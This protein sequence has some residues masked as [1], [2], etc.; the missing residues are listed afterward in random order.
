MNR[1]VVILATLGCLGLIGLVG[2]EQARG[3]FVRIRN[4]EQIGGSATRESLAL[5]DSLDRVGQ[6]LE[7]LRGELQSHPTQEVDQRVEAMREE[8]RQSDARLTQLLEQLET[9]SIELE[10]LRSAQ[11][12]F[13]P[14]TLNASLQVFDEEISARWNSVYHIASSAAEL[15]GRSQ[16]EVDKLNQ[17]LSDAP[18]NETLWR[19]LLGPV[20]QLSGDDSI[21][22]GVLFLSPDSA[23]A[24]TYVLTAWHVVRDIQ[25]SLDQRDMPIPISIYESETR[26]RNEFGTLLEYDA[27][28]DVALLK[29]DSPR[30]VEHTARMSTLEGLQAI[31]IFE[32]IYAI[33]CP[34]GNDPIPT[35][36]QV[37]AKSH[38]VDGETYMMINAP[39]YVG[40]SGGGIFDADTHE[41]LGIFSK[42]YT[43]GSLR[44]TIVT[45]MGLVTPMEVIYEWMS[46]VGFEQLIPRPQQDLHA[47]A[48]A[49]CTSK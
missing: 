9:Q 39:T 45:H 18:T 12:A 26:V 1:I 11:A 44:P 47:A 17:R 36:G 5:R 22:S 16:E 20:V 24:N 14:E 6:E 15:A 30:P 28:I 48:P 27:S 19:H 34:L 8:L 2:S 7:V 35:L 32:S 31:D 37:S 42:V 25:G 49:A 43:H 33:G 3:L 29:L 23:D 10:S 41:L 46:N 38:H 21:G 4:L 40:N 13:G